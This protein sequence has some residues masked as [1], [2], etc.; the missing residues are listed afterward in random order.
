MTDYGMKV[1]GIAAE[2]ISV[3][4]ARTHL[5]IVAEGSPPSSDDDEWLETIG[6]PAAR[7]WCEHYLGRSIAQ[8]TI[9]L[10]ADSF[11]GDPIPLTF[12]PAASITSIIYTDADDVSQQMD[13]ADY[14][15]DD[16]VNP[17]LIRLTPDAVWPTSSGNSNS[18]KIRY[19][20]GYSLAGDSP[21]TN[22]LPAGIRAALLLTLGH[23]F[24]NRENSVAASSAVGSI[25][26][27][28][29]GAAS[30]LERYR[31]RNSMA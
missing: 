23:L 13:S 15:L 3:E 19:A 10:S 20:A 2:P 14:F 17:P 9:E 1:I 8:Q 11:S 28:P 22:P 6:I 4:E 26:L 21:Q 7:D 31:L 12:G 24:E 30:L 18:V 27:I 29:Q 16:Y 25:E 5:R